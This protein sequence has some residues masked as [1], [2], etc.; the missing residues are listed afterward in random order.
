MCLTIGCG[1][2]STQ[3]RSP[4][5]SNGVSF[6]GMGSGPYSSVSWQ[7]NLAQNSRPCPL[8]LHL[9]D[10]DLTQ[11]DLADAGKL[12]SRGW[13]ETYSNRQDGVIQLTRAELDGKREKTLAQ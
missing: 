6:F 10:G 8:V 1:R 3:S 9:P 12:R 7:L 11:A 5:Y 13:M 4:V 2:W